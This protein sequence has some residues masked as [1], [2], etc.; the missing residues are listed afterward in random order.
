[1][2]V[3][4]NTLRFYYAVS[5][6]SQVAKLQESYAVNSRQVPVILLLH[7]TLLCPL[8][9]TVHI[10]ESL[11]PFIKMI[12]LPRFMLKSYAI[13]TMYSIVYGSEEAINTFKMYLKVGVGIYIHRN[14]P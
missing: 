6:N 12:F 7:F 11:K 4:G 14:I 13:V 2:H 10:L 8:H 5:P 3:H 9:I 1:M